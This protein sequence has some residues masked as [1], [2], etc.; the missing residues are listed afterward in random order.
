MQNL[1]NGTDKLIHKTETDLENEHMVTREEGSDN[2]Q[3][4]DV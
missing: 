3:G 1:K 2:Q 4:P